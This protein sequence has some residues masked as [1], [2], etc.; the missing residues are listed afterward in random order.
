MPM[1]FHE[2]EDTIKN[3]CT[4]NAPL[5]SFVCT[6]GLR[7]QGERIE[8]SSRNVSFTIPLEEVVDVRVDSFGYLVISTRGFCGFHILYS[9]NA[10]GDVVRQKLD[11]P[12]A[13]HDFLKEL[14]KVLD[15]SGRELIPRINQGDD[16]MIGEV[17]IPRHGLRQITM[18]YGFLVLVYNDYFLQFRTKKVIKNEE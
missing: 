1:T 14:N 12:F 3:L 13:V 18:D 17:I 2:I 11:M 9:L 4:E 16:F 15:E 10:E 6:W 8:L 7:D 5:N